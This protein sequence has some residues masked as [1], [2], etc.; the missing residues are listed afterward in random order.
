MDSLRAILT[1]GLLTI[2]YRIDFLAKRNRRNLSRVSDGR[3]EIDDFGGACSFLRSM[4]LRS[5]F[6][7]HCAPLVRRPVIVEGN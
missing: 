2:L 6:S 1:C 7:V 4:F 3:N 5:I